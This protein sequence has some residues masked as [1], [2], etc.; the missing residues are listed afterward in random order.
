MVAYHDLRCRY[1]IKASIKKST[2]EA[3]GDGGGKSMTIGHPIRAGV[4]FTLVKVCYDYSR[5]IALYT[6]HE[7]PGKEI[8]CEGEKFGSAEELLTSSSF[9]FA[10][11]SK[12]DYRPSFSTSGAEGVPAEVVYRRAYQK[13]R[14]GVL[15]G[16]AAVAEKYVNED[17][18][19]ARGHL[20]PDADFVYSS[21]QFGT[22]FY[23]NVVPQWQAINSGNWRRIETLARKRAESLNGTLRVYTGSHGV[24]KLRDLGGDP[25]EIYLW[26]NSLPV[27]EVL[28]KI[29]YDAPGKRAVVFLTVND[30]FLDKTGYNYLCNDVCDSYG[31]QDEHWTDSSRGLVYCCGYEEFRDAVRAAPRIQV[32]QVLESP[33]NN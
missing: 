14:L 28:W 30:P 8:E 9:V 10:V 7:I 23:V 25:V 3:C 27:P 29:L 15:L 26:K 4:W 19:L 33:R 21:G 32:D 12:N 31:W 24:L 18:Y 16:S 11:R 2:E 5:W 1:K 20:A 22:Y 6:E 13:A 17:S